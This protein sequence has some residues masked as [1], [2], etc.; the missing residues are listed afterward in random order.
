MKQRIRMVYLTAFISL[1][2]R[3]VQAQIQGN[4]QSSTVLTTTTGALGVGTFNPIVWGEIQYCYDT[5]KGF[6]I[7]KKNACSG[8]TNF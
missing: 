3:G 1:A 7:T 8:S 6:V 5:E 4:W 2:F